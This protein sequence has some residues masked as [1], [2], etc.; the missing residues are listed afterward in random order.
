[1][2]Q[3]TS[4]MWTV[5]ATVG[6]LAIVSASGMLLTSFQ[7]HASIAEL[8]T[9]ETESKHRDE[10]LEEEYRAHRAIAEKE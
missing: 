6:A 3:W 4:V 8:D 2:G 9:V 10:Q 7:G 5:V 1:M